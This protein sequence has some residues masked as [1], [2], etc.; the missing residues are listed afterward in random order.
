MALA[1]LALGMVLPRPVAWAAIAVQAVLCWPLVL[2]TWETRYSFRLHQFQSIH[3]AKVFGDQGANFVDALLVADD[4]FFAA[5]QFF[6][7][8]LGHIDFGGRG[9]GGGE[10]L[11]RF[12]FCQDLGRVPAGGDGGGVI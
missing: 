4:V 6:F 5:F 2:D 7:T 8:L 3:I 9:A 12:E 1:A 10:G 11:V